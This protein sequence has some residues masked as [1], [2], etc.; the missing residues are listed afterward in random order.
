MKQIICYL[1]LFV[2]VGF[3]QDGKIQRAQSTFSV[4]LDSTETATFFYKFDD[5]AP[6]LTAV[7][8]EDNIRSD[9]CLLM[10]GWIDSAAAVTTTEYDSLAGYA[11]QLTHDGYLLND[12]LF[13]DFTANGIGDTLQY[14]SWTP[15][16][17]AGRTIGTTATQ[18]YIDF[19]TEI[20]NS[21]GLKIVWTQVAADSNGTGNG[22]RSTIENEFVESK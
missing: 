22:V 9:R 19:G 13:F 18:F 17:R 2:S 16:S 4:E 8:P 14:L 1:I 15:F 11:I 10:Y 21:F 5:G 12:T 20:D 3:A 7:N 6:S